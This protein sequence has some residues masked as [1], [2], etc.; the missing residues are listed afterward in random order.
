MLIF[1]ISRMNHTQQNLLIHN[2]FVTFHLP[3][4]S[5]LRDFETHYELRNKAQ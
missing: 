5:I 4:R 3:F 2:I 1:D